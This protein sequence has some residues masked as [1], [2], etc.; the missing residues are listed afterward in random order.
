MFLEELFHTYNTLFYIYT[1]Y[2]SYKSKD[3]LK[4]VT[5]F[6]RENIQPRHSNKNLRVKKKVG[7]KR[8]VTKNI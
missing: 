8:F 2:I 1:G 4:D 7:E 3:L 6:A 5:Y